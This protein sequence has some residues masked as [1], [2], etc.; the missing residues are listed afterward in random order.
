MSSKRQKHIEAMQARYEEMGSLGD[1]PE[2]VLRSG[3]L[4]ELDYLTHSKRPVAVPLS[5]GLD[6]QVILFV[7]HEL[8]VPVV[9]Y[10]FALEGIVS[11]DLQ[12]ARLAAK[13]LDI[14]HRTVWLPKDPQKFLAFAKWCLDYT[15]NPSKPFNICLWASTTLLKQAHKDGVR[16]IVWGFGSDYYFTMSR[17]FG[18]MCKALPVPLEEVFIRLLRNPDDQLSVL[19]SLGVLKDMTMV[20]PYMNA[21]YLARMI[22]P[23]FTYA[24]AN[25]P[26]EKWLLRREFQDYLG[27]IKV[28]NHQ[29]YQLGDTGIDEFAVRTLIESPWNVKGYKDAGAVLRYALDNP[30]VFDGV[31]PE[32]SK[33]L[34]KTKF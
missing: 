23:K 27:K 32:D 4:L 18:S 31:N 1:L 30:Q 26:R 3:L 29:N 34:R 22:G 12:Y 25:S 20:A 19:R 13:T 21:S 6:S 15:Q 9:A 14:E 24:E 28:L 10:T 16:Q 7:L 11:K 17:K 33:L 5:S 2:N 8:K